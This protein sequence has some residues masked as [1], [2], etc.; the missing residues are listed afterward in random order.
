M[1]I[2]QAVDGSPPRRPAAGRC[3]AALGNAAAAAA[4]PARHRHPVPARPPRRRRRGAGGRD[5]RRRRA[6]RLQPR[7]RRARSTIA[8][9]ARALG[10]HSVPVP[11]PAVGARR[12]PSPAAS[13]SSPPSSSGSTALEIPVL[14]DTAKARREL[15]WEPR[16]DAAETLMQTRGRGPR[17]GPA[18]LSAPLRQRSSARRGRRR[19]RLGRVADVVAV[20]LDRERPDG[21]VLVRR[22]RGRPSPR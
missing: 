11:E 18:G 5:R 16:F 14:M 12:R 13:P 4:G 1:L 20:D 22:D 10:W 2:E 15:G 8:D 17:R 19:A 9:V 7:R 6:R 3:A 21:A